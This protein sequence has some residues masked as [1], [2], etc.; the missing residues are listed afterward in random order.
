V[1]CRCTD[2]AHPKKDSLTEGLMMLANRRGADLVE[3]IVGVIIV[4]GVLSGS[5]YGLFQVIGDKLDE[6]TGAISP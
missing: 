6:M 3:W 4:L 5:M 1:A 2:A